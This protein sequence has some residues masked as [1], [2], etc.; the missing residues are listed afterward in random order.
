MT[1]VLVPIRYPLSSWSETTLRE[2]MRITEEFDA[3]LVVL[4]V[5][6]YRSKRRVRRVD[7]KR[8]VERAVGRVPRARYV[9][10]SGLLIEE[11]ILEEIAAEDADIVVVGKTQVTRWRR[12]MRWIVD[13]PDVGRY[14]RRKL[15]CRIVTVAETDPR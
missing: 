6:E 2:A 12:I 14:L 4:H 11:T 15:D 1:L 5:T 3:D 9:V 10:R 8:A 7:L 13:D